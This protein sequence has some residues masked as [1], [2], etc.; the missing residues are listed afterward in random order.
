SEVEAARAASAAA[1]ARLNQAS[2]PDP[3]DLEVAQAAL[4]SSTAILSAAQA[5]I[6][7][8]RSGASTLEVAQLMGEVERVR[9]A[10]E[11]A[12]AEF[13]R[14]GQWHPDPADVQIAQLALQAAQAQ[15]EDALAAYQ[16]V[17]ERTGDANHPDAIVA[18]S[19]ISTTA[20]LVDTAR[21]RA[22]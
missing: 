16:T 12:E 11:K 18:A 20:A 17:Y 8:L 19:R 4:D 9:E 21:S 13:S 22:A 7:R 14:L 15:L 3:A 2:G 1:K 5:R 10:A 6:Q